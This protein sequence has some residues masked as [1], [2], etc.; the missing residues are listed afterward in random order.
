MQ[1]AA[2]G[3]AV[4]FAE[5]NDLLLTDRTAQAPMTEHSR[6]AASLRAAHS[7]MVSTQHLLGCPRFDVLS[8][9]LTIA[10]WIVAWPWALTPLVA[11]RGVHSLTMLQGG[12]QQGAGASEAGR[13]L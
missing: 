10:C 11:C 9:V 1:G 12:R 3:R 8:R 5:P 7:T 6:Q 13:G 4:A 2:Q